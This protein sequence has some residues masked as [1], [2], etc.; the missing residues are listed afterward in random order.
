MNQTDI[1]RYYPL[2]SSVQFSSVAQS[3]PTLLKSIKKIRTPLWLLTSTFQLLIWLL[4]HTSS[5]KQIQTLL[6]YHIINFFRINYEVSPALIL[7]LFVALIS[8]CLVAVWGKEEQSFSLCIGIFLVFLSSRKKR[9]WKLSWAKRMTV[10]QLTSIF[11]LKK[12]L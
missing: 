8:I 6:C 7:Y 12:V 11:W 2:Y 1:S 5:C 10:I 9:M 4:G 3:C